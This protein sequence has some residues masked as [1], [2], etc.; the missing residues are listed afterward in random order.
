VVPPKAGWNFGNGKMEFAN[1][2]FKPQLPIA[3]RERYAT[4]DKRKKPLGVAEDPF[5]ELPFFTK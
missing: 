1:Q 4:F 5:P 3:N 2:E